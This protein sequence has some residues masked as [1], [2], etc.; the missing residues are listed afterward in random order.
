MA[1]VILFALC[2]CSLPLDADAQGPLL[3]EV[4]EDIHGGTD[5]ARAITLSGNVAVVVGN[6]GEPLEGTDESDFVIQALSRA[7]GTLRWSDRTFLSIGVVQQI[8]VTSRDH[9]AYAV[10]TLYESDGRSAFLV[11]AYDVPSGTL[12]WENVWHASP[13]IDT[14]HPQG[15]IA[16]PTQVVVVGYGANATNNGLALLVRAYDPSTGT[17][18]WEDRRSQSGADVVGWAVA[19]NAGRVFVVGTTSGTGGPGLLVRA[20]DASSGHVA[21]ETIRQNV[22]PTEM[23]VAAGRLLVAGSAANNTYLV[24]LSA[25][26]G[27]LLWE[28]PT[29]IVGAFVDIAVDGPRL[30]GAVVSG[31]G[32][33]VR[34]YNVVTGDLEWQ[35]RPT[36]PLGFHATVLAVGVNSNGV[37]AAG[38]SGRIFSDSEFMVR[39]YDARNGT[40]LWDDRSHLSPDSRATDLVLDNS[41]LFVAG[42]TVEASTES[43]FLLRAYDVG[44]RPHSR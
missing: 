25:K 28:D 22:T 17:V 29:P 42:Y 36:V 21:W 4:Q 7:T 9:R 35:D 1:R 2:L 8:F 40:L 14:D 44:G 10:G 26:T 38:S 31:V 30:V 39:A 15:I 32:F 5:I 33:A 18:L 43:D 19:A 41:R 16:T 11:R 37:Y 13:G 6:G 34:T 12:L 24:A 27:S 3:W 20:Y 23:L